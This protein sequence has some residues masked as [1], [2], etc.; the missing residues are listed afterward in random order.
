MR[1]V[2]VHVVLY[3]AMALLICIL[4]GVVTPVKAQPTCTVTK[5]SD[6]CVLVVRCKRHRGGV[7]V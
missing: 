6:K 5:E 2:V 3:A 7:C 4:L 1:V